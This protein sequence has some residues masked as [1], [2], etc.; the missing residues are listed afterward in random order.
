MPEM[1]SLFSGLGGLDAGHKGY[2]LSLMVDL[3]AGAMSGGGA[4]GPNQ[5]INT[6]NFTVIAISSAW[7]PSGRSWLADRLRSNVEQSS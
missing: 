1:V 3:M 6:N 7:P 5:P 2:A 4:S